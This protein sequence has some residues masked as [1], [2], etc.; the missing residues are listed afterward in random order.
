[1]IRHHLSETDR[2]DTP[3]HLGAACEQ[4]IS[5]KDICSDIISDTVNAINLCAL[6]N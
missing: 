6:I 5:V 1:M 3:G 2:A 4:T